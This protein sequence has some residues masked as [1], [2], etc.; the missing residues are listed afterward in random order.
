MKQQGHRIGYIRVSSTDQATERQLDGIDLD[1]VYTDKA[2]GKDVNRPELEKMLRYGLRK[3]DTLYVHSLDRLARNAEDLLRIVRE[4]TQERGVT[5][6]FIKNRMTFSGS[7]ADPMAT[8]MLTML[9][10]FAAFERELIRERQREGIALA[11]QRGAYKGRKRALTDAQVAEALRRI[12]DGQ[13]KAMIA[14]E[15]KV[16]RE[17]LYQSLRRV[18]GIAA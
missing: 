9:A 11:K 18:A 10:G 5:V 13:P 14:K 1:H 8:L 12:A 15:L 6:E 17:T 3:G 4:L 7:K 16:S 2:S